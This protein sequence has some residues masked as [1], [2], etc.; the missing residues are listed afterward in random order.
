MTV[1]TLI[2]GC[3]E[4]SPKPFTKRLYKVV[5]CHKQIWGSLLMESEIRMAC[6]FTTDLI[7]DLV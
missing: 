2:E 3:P 1:H 7:I 5:Q 6:T 4:T